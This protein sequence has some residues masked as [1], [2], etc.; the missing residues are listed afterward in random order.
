MAWDVLEL[1]HEI[2]VCCCDGEIASVLRVSQ[3]QLKVWK[4]LLAGSQLVCHIHSVSCVDPLGY[5][6][7]FLCI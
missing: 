7:Q 1:M 3:R 6:L 5:L 4:R 2:M